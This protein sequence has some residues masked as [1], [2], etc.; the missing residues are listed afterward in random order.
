MKHFSEK[1]W[2]L[3][4][5]G[6]YPEEKSRLMEE[7]LKE[8]PNCMDMFLNSINEREIIEAHKAIPADFTN[9]VIKMINSERKAP[10]PPK[11]SI[12]WVKKNQNLL[13][14]YAAAAVLTIALMGG[15]AFQAFVTNST[16][17]AGLDV[18]PGY[19]ESLLRQFDSIQPDLNQI[20]QK[21]SLCNNQSHYDGYSQGH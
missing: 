10:M 8:C 13:A 7:H 20:Q 6:E 11:R 9:T 18:F 5:R 19:R 3:F 4:R 1:E 15:G 14:Y 21:G 16:N 2:Q 12:G 17:A